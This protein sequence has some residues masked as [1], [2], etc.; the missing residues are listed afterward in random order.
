[1]CV[2]NCVDSHNNVRQYELA[3][4]KKWLT[5][6]PFFRL[7][8]TLTG[9]TVT[10]VWKLAS[11]HKLISNAKDE[12]G[13]PVISIKKFSGKLAHQLINIAVR[14]P[15][16]ESVMALPSSISSVAPKQA[17]MED[18]IVEYIQM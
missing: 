11:F 9:I 5:Q 16:L 14:L 1:M 2:S 4:E 3:L 7:H 17:M 12:E 8:T 10:D 6:D 18:M 15:S 13:K